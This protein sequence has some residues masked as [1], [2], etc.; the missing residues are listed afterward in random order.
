M[1]HRDPRAPPGGGHPPQLPVPIQRERWL[2]LPADRDR[3][4][5]YPRSAVAP[6]VS[7]PPAATRRRLRLLR[8]RVEHEPGRPR[9]RAD[10]VGDA[11]RVSGL[12][13]PLPRRPRRTRGGRRPPGARGGRRPPGTRGSVATGRRPAAPAAERSIDAGGPVRV[14]AARGGRRGHAA[15]GHAF[16]RIGTCSRMVCK[17]GSVI[18]RRAL[19]DRGAG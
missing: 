2:H 15:A 7:R 10:D 14:G 16:A 5:G 17:E 9:V 4:R 11:G 6:G 12:P 8:G 1:R 18:C 13:L 3:A 19:A